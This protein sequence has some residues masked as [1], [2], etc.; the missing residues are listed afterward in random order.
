MTDT[1]FTNSQSPRASRDSTNDPEKFAKGDVSLG[2]DDP[3]KN[4]QPG[5]DIKHDRGGDGY[6]PA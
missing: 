3:E 1:R 4:D 5:W 2:M 6:R